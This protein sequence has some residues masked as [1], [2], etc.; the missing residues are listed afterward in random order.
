[1]LTDDI[2]AVTAQEGGTWIPWED[3]LA[4]DHRG[5]KRFHSILFKDGQTWDEINGFRGE[6][7]DYTPEDMKIVHE[8][9]PSE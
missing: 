3:F 2:F 9:W 6:Q 5:P 4:F 7:M 8:N 1:M